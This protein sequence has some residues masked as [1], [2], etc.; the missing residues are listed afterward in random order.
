MVDGT[1]EGLEV[2]SVIGLIVEDLGGVMWQVKRF[3]VG[4]A[5]WGSHKVFLGLRTPSRCE[6]RF[7]SGLCV[8]ERVVTGSGYGRIQEPMTH[9][10]SAFVFVRP[11]NLVLL[12]CTAKLVRE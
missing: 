7:D 9:Q 5:K 12:N 2:K 8:N 11:F 10:H 3:I 4:G 1:F 6:K